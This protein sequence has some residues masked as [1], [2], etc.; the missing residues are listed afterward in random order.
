[1]TVLVAIGLLVSVLI[2]IFLVRIAV[3][4]RAIREELLPQIRTELIHRNKAGGTLF[5]GIMSEHLHF[6]VQPEGCFLVWVWRS[7]NWSLLN[8]IPEG[9]ERTLPPNYPG[10]FDGDCSKTWA[11][12]RR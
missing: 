2:L 9:V 7:G 10:A 1:M 8:E 6:N 11:S 5:R 4:I 12:T 3:D